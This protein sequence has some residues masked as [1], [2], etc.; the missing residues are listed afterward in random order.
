M[1]GIAGIINLSGESVSASSIEIMLSKIRHRGPDAEGI[2]IKE[3]IGLGHV[4]LSIIDLSAAGH[5]PMYSNDQ[6]YLIIFNGEIY[7]YLELRKEL[8]GSYLFKSKTDTEVL[9]ASYIIWGESCLS[10]LNGDFSFVIYDTEERTIFGARDRFGIKPFYY[11]H[12]S[13]KFIFASEIKAILPVL[14]EVKPNN[15][16]IYEYL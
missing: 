10:K 5:Q 9:L 3:N 7:N 6:R 16:S 2:Y 13:E 15:K 1:C 8:E 11:H 14:N 4:R 12:D